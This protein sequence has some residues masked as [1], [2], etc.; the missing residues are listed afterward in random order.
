M[1]IQREKWALGLFTSILF[2]SALACLVW[3]VT[4]AGQPALYYSVY[5][6][7]GAALMAVGAICSAPLPQR[8]PIRITL[9]PTAC[10]VCASALPVP[11]VV[12]CT[13]VGVSVARLVVS[14]SRSS[15]LHK[16]IHNSS[17]DVVT[18]AAAGSV[19]YSF[20][21]QPG[22]SEA[23]VGDPNLVRH[24]IAFLTAAVAVLALEELV[25]IT[26]V[27]LATGRPFL[28]VLRHLWR[29][30]LIVAVGEIVTA[31]L[32]AVVTGL[33]LRALIQILNCQ[34]VS[35]SSVSPV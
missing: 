24:M 17:M 32:V 30:R 22:F 16:T 29:T 9:T 7:M 33:D 18:A 25:T 4:H 20:G 6:F 1:P 15:G 8:V 21:L 35:G 3:A 28:L 10:L 23:D 26:T 13:A 14:R 5:L 34:V 27:R 12:L 31:G 19:M 11:W 2:A